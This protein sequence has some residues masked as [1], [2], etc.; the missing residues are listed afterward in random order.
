MTP[1][2][3][4]LNMLDGATLISKARKVGALARP[5]QSK[6][7]GR[8]ELLSASKRQQHRIWRLQ[9]SFSDCA[10]R[11]RPGWP[12]RSPRRPARSGLMAL[13]ETICGLRSRF[14]FSAA[15][16]VSW[17]RF[18]AARRSSAATPSFAFQGFQKF[19]SNGGTSKT[20]PKARTGTSITPRTGRTKTRLNTSARTLSHRD[21]TVTPH[22]DNQFR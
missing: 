19:E 7:K 1:D 16:I 13:T 20:T 10:G 12:S 21:A 8:V 2:V 5:V 17:K 9:P 18:V 3:D 15:E 11:G 4:D 22:P 6:K 14:R